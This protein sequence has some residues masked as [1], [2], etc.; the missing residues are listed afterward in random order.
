MKKVKQQS[1][2][3][4]VAG[5]A[6]LLT[7]LVEQSLLTQ[8]GKSLIERYVRTWQR[9]TTM[10]AF[11]ALIETALVTEADLANASANYWGMPRLYH[12]TG[13]EVPEALLPRFPFTQARAW[14]CL[15][16]LV[17]GGGI[18]FVVANPWY[19]QRMQDLKALGAVVGHEITLA[20][21]ERGDILKAI[22]E[23]YPLAAQLP[24]LLGQDFPGMP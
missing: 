2:S 13:M 16:L 10:T 7:F 20:V 15:P 8:S 1:P 22:D 21:G 14:E 19:G 11:Q 4:P 9:T 6:E 24:C 3:G 17:D 23:L 18:E 12:L 5:D